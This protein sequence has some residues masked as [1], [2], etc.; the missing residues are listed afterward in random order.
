MEEVL[1]F[2]KP[3]GCQS[4]AT[5][6]KR[7]RNAGEN[8]QIKIIFDG[9]LP[10]KVSLYILIYPV[11]NIEFNLKRCPQILA[12]RKSYVLSVEKKSFLAECP[13]K[14]GDDVPLCVSL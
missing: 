5:E 9:E 10:S 6:I 1:P 7:L 14:K 2:I 4:K 11:Q 12:V 13:V 3:A 8:E